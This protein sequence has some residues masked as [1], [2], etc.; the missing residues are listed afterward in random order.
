MGMRIIYTQFRKSNSNR[1]LGTDTWPAD[2]IDFRFS[3][4]TM[5][6]YTLRTKFNCCNVSWVTRSSLNK[7]CLL[8]MQIQYCCVSEQKRPQYLKRNGE[9][10][11]KGNLIRGSCGY[12]G[13]A[14]DSR[15]TQ[16]RFSLLRQMLSQ[17]EKR[18]TATYWLRKYNMG[19][20]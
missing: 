8:W 15:P 9:E 11:T 20:C 10:G 18:E 14:R 19:R 16:T 4:L 17:L 5:Q 13:I 6:L 7:E 2:K 1:P 12:S 3:F